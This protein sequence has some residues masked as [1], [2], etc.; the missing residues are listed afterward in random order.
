M[1]LFHTN[2]NIENFQRLF[3]R[4]M[5]TQTFFFF[6]I[7]FL[8]LLNVMRIEMLNFVFV[9]LLQRFSRIQ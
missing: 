7:D 3:P 2:S 8:F 9:A 5:H 1:E 6:I 4:N